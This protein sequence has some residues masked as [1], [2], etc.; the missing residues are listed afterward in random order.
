MEETVKLNAKIEKK[1]NLKSLIHYK[2]LKEIFGSGISNVSNDL[3]LLNIMAD[4]IREYIIENNTNTEFKNFVVSVNKVYDKRAHYMNYSF[5]IR[6]QSNENQRLVDYYSDKARFTFDINELYGNCST[7]CFNNLS[8]SGRY[9]CK[10]EEVSEMCKIILETVLGL[11][12]AF[13]YTNVM[14]TTS[15]ESNINKTLE[16][17]LIEKDF[18]SIDKFKNKRGG[19]I[20]FYSKLI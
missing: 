1:V 8:F 10:S 20:T 7:C 17:R 19:H 12:K 18:K 3:G 15:S 9:D 2:N 11:C 16:K 5:S 13:E 4:Y 6:A 14:Y